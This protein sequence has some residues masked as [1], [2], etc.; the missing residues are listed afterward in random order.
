[1]TLE[2]I[3]ENYGDVEF[4]KADGF[5][6]AVIGIEQVHYRL[7]YDIDRMIKILIEREGMTDEEALEYLDYNVIGAYVGEQTP[8]YIQI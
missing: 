5:D 4:L 8:L 1:M 7:V 3:L 2:E 6:E